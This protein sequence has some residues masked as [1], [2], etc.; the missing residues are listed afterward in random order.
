MANSVDKVFQG[1]LANDGHGIVGVTIVGLQQNGV[2]GQPNAAAVYMDGF[3]SY[4]PQGRGLPRPGHL[5]APVPP[6]LYS[7]AAGEP[8]GIPRLVN[9]NNFSETNVTYVNLVVTQTPPVLTITMNPGGSH[10]VPLSEDSATGV[11]TGNSNEMFYT[12]A[13]GTPYVIG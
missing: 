11:M 3:L 2:I 5:P 8:S 6:E 10:V 9:G 4:R 7:G 12:V 13:F 1:F